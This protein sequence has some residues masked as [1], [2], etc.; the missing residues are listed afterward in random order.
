M[1]QFAGANGRAW[2]S[3]E[4]LSGEVSLSIPQ[5][6]R[7]VRSLEEKGFIRR[8]TR[9][10]RSNAFEF[11][12]HGV[13]EQSGTRP[14]LPTI[15]HPRSPE[16]TRPR[17]SVIAPAESPRIASERSSVIARRESVESSSIEKIQ[18]KESQVKPKTQAA[19]WEPVGNLCRS[20]FLD[21]D[22]T[23]RTVDREP[24]ANPDEEFLQRLRDRHGNSI[25]PEAI[26][27]SV[28]ETLEWQATDLKE[29]L[30]FDA[31]QTTAP[32]K[33]TNPPGH[34]RRTAEKF[35]LARAK[36]REIDLRER[37]RAL[38]NSLQNR[39]DQL[40]KPTCSLSS[41]DGNGEFW[42]ESGLVSACQC[43]A[44]KN[45][46]PAVLDLFEKLNSQRRTQP[47]A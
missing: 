28:L 26:L 31:R 35:R 2:P 13:Y 10:G 32:N 14:R 44:G 8:V 40:P 20:L 12:W 37:Q 46:S 22:D 3:V 33:L 34:Y 27:Q 41:C 15:T 19:T 6:R 47:H 39:R 42:S 43:E 16:I 36:R 5:T 38:E 23:R 21:E 11:L 25:N 4:R 7:C 17:S 9:S 29:F 1:T 24:L 45:L 18:R 30:D